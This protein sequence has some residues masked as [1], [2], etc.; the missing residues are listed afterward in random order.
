MKKLHIL[1][2]LFLCFSIPLL[3]Q[4]KERPDLIKLDSTWGKEMFTF[5]LGFARDIPY[6]GIEEARFPKGWKDTESS[7]FWTYTFAWSIANDSLLTAHD[8][9]VDL[10]HYFDGIMSIEIEQKSDRTIANTSAAFLL[11]EETLQHSKL[12]GKIHSWDHF[13]TKMPITLYAEVD[14]YY[15]KNQEKVIV[16]FRFSPKEF[17]HEVWNTMRAISLHEDACLH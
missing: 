13:T 17:T 9:E 8:L 5:P 16:L 6:Q 1:G 15:C 11:K 2:T 3:G 10:Q 4:E 12:V 14:Q 7:F